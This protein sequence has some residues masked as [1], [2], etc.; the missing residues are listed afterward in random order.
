MSSELT[1]EFKF[2]LAHQEE[3]VE[4]YDGRVIALKGGRVL[5][6]YDSE[7]AA[8]TELQKSHA[9]GTF[10]VQRV[11]PGDSAYTQTFYSPRAVFQ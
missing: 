4:Q 6:V 3:M 9:L 11:T 2:Y 10:L 1:R 5:G 7:L 8:V